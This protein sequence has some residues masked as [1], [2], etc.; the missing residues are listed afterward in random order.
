MGHQHIPALPF[1]AGPRP[2]KI[3]PS[4]IC[5]VQAALEAL[6][7][8]V[9]DQEGLRAQVGD[10]LSSVELQRHFKMSFLISAEPKEEMAEKAT[11]AMHHF[12][13][14]AAE[15]D[16]D[17]LESLGASLQMEATVAILSMGRE[18]EQAEQA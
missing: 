6:I 18:E 4:K 17:F 8:M 11:L 7:I 12:L 10:Y 13:V 9:Q 16:W 15:A 2:L 3:S 5:C 1:K 14:G